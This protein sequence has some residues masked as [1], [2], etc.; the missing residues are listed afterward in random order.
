V[1][2]ARPYARLV[3]QATASPAGEDLEAATVAL[4]A[5]MWRRGSGK[6]EPHG[7]GSV[8]RRP[9]A[10]EGPPGC[11]LRD[12]AGTIARAAC[13]G[14]RYATTT[15]VRSDLPTLSWNDL[16]SVGRRGRGSL[17]MRSET[18]IGRL[19]RRDVVRRRRRP[20]RLCAGMNARWR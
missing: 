13:R 4:T 18:V 6:H 14:G 5:R 9:P 1:A 19:R 17:P 2:P 15:A 12:R 7:R 8:V 3:R 16:T 11:Q 10:K 20:G